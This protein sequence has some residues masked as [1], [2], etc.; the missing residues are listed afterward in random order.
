MQ[1]LQ[2]DDPSKIGPYALIARLGTGGMGV[3]YLARS[4]GG[5]TVA[6]KV[7]RPELAA[8]GDFR[9]RF[10]REVEAAQS[11]SG[12]YTAPVV[13]FDHDAATPW[14][15]TAYVLGP[16]LAEAVAAHGPL[17]EASVRTLGAVLAEALR[18]IHGAGLVHRDLKPSNVLL[19]ADGPRVIDFGIARALDG[20]GG[21]LTSTGVVVGSPGYMAPEQASGLPIGPA[22]DVFS[23]GS[24]LSY[25]A[26]GHGPFEASSVA[27]LLYKVVHE[28]PELAALPTGLREPVGACLAKAPG[29]RITPDTLLA[30]LAPEGTPALL[31]TAWLPAAVASGIASHA[32]LVM[33]L[34][35]PVREPS[36][37]DGG[38]LVLGAGPS[39]TPAGAWTPGGASPA[40]VRLGGGAGSG[41]VPMPGPGDGTGRGPRRRAVIGAAGAGAL[42]LIGGGTALA[43]AHNKKQDPK[44][45]PAPT[46]SGGSSTAPAPS[47]YPTRAPGVPPQPL[48]TYQGSSPGDSPVLPYQGKLL[49]NGDRMVAVDARGGKQ[50]WQGPMTGAAFAYPPFAVGAGQVITLPSDALGEVV[51][52]N[53]DTGA[54]VWKTGLPQRDAFNVF[55]AADDT[56]AYYLGEEYPLDAK[57]Q[58][59]IDS[60]LPDT[61]RIF[62]LDLHTHAI[63][64]K[65]PRKASASNFVAGSVSGK[66]LIY[67]NDTNNVVVRDTVKGAQLW[68]GDFGTK[69]FQTQVE[70]LVA[71]GVLYVGGP[72]LLGF[73][74]SDG[75][76]V[77]GI[78]NPGGSF[79]T[80]AM[81]D[82]LLFT[83]D[84]PDGSVVALS[85][86]TGAR[87]WVCPMRD[88]TASSALVVIG[89]TLFAVSG[90]ASDG[91]YAI[92][93]GTGKI[94]WN[95]QDG[96]DDD[97]WLSTDGQ[98]L[99]AVHGDR[100]YAL[101]P[102]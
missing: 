12:A 24:V 16:S 74:I 44:P 95:Y 92:D 96:Q 6:V 85:A 72:K 58:P 99:Y 75:K 20:T 13:D 98:V 67:T 8:S 26:T 63:A 42:V 45:D 15:A 97:W 70:P 79:D 83:V 82:G 87:Q 7:V 41:T 9:A 78:A 5:R 3:V 38:T 43:L 59:V 80:P 93:T 37:A 11:V 68:S 64:W 57:G 19:A 101:P 14:L 81:A 69:D 73:R 40:T 53:P 91:V 46:A 49:V 4:V 48:W 52:V 89:K 102:R 17:P 22:G 28:P 34:E 27:G 18:A 31:R 2:S 32:A 62:A 36:A 76:Q 47:S 61:S 33:D 55:V 60:T 66:Y 23:L 65:Q 51:A 77:L 71:N 29:D 25:A 84:H 56:H 1:P 94:L 88:R 21:E 30:L 50:L 86:A 54:V 90:V 39:G 10:R 35:A 100:V